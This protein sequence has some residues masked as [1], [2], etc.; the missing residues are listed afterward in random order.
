MAP[1]PPPPEPHGNTET[2]EEIHLTPNGTA[3]AFQVADKL[4]FI[5]PE[6]LSPEERRST[7]DRLR[8]QFLSRTVT[9]RIRRLAPISEALY[10][11]EMV[12]TNGDP[13]VFHLSEQDV[14]HN[15][16]VTANTFSPP[17]ISEY[18]S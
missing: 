12:G 10:R 11:C 2:S 16:S 13:L 15:L 14:M 1:H 9:Y 4:I 7:C 8:K 3:T 6:R 18:A 5:L 17:S